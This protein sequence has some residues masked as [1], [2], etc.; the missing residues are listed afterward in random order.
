MLSNYA[1]Y[2]LQ[3]DDSYNGEGRHSSIFPIEHSLSGWDIYMNDIT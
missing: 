1:G 3:I 2:Y